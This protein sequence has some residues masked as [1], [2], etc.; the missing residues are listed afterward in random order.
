MNSQKA[1]GKKAIVIGSN[2][3][4]LV[5]ARILADYFESV[6]ILENNSSTSDRNQ[7][8]PVPTLVTKAYQILDSLF[9]GIGYRLIQKGALAIDWAREFQVFG[10]FGWGCN[11]QVPSKIISIICTRELL[12]NTIKEVLVESYSNVQ[13]TSC[14]LEG[15]FYDSITQQ[16]AGINI[17]NKGLKQCLDCNLVIDTALDSLTP[18]Y[19]EKIGFS[20]PSETVIDPLITCAIRRYKLSSNFPNNLK[21]MLLRPFPP[22]RTQMA[23]LTRIEGKEFVV[24]LGEYGSEFSCVSEE[25]FLRIALSLPAQNLYDIIARSTATSEILIGSVK[26]NR[27]RHYE[28]IKLPENLIILG[29]AACLLSPLYGQDTTTDILGANLLKEFFEQEKSLS[30]FASSLAKFNSPFWSLATNLDLRFETTTFKSSL[31]G[32]RRPDQQAGIVNDFVNWYSGRL[33]NKTTTDPDLYTLWLE[34]IHLLKDPREFF[35]PLVITKV[36][37]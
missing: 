27:L 21:A 2:V 7:I 17:L 5:S 20:S 24:A 11:S 26:P 13:L 19:L 34:V 12:E 15:F 37:I 18:Q 4:G 8:A 32:V 23:C 14:S 9:P 29:N 30:D 35:N 31:D 22:N 28:K 6:T 16:I 3:A 36:L 33:V 1:F 25:D 10:Y